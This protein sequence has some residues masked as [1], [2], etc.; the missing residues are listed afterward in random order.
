MKKYKYRRQEVYKDVPIDVRADSL[1]ELLSKLAAKRA[2]IDRY[3]LSPNTKL[4]DF[5]MKVIETYK[6][7]KVSASWYDSIEGFVRK[8]I[9]PGIGNK[10]MGKIKPM[11]VE[12]FLIS[13]SD[14]ADSHIKKIF[15]VTKLIFRYAYKNGLTPY[16]YS[17]DFVMPRGTPGKTGRSITDRERETLL[18]I[19]PGHRG[20]IFCKLILCCGLRPGEVCALKWADIDFNNA[21]LNVNKALKKDGTVGDP[22]S[23]AGFRLVPIP[24]ELL[25]FLRSHKGSPFDLVCPQSNGKY[26]THTTR[27]KMWKSVCRAMNI[28]MGCRIF[29]NELLPPY[30]LADDFT[31]YNLRH[32]YCT[33]LEKMGVPINIARRLMGHSSIEVTSRIYTHASQ[34]SFE[35]AR[36]LINQ[37]NTKANGQATTG[38][39]VEK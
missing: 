29:R 7:P 32:T 22:K 23:A 10:P 28:E 25:D 35:T 34:E 6:R 9:V 24:E 15:D 38:K 3:S 39:T 12:E 21:S 19:L 26:H 8:K 11:D 30:P 27:V 33:D 37:K 17:D 36:I 5:S 2:Q 4:L 14:L 31:M 20:E 1:D 16:D 18:K 13:L